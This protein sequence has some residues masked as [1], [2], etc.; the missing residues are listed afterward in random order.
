M[1]YFR[2]L[3]TFQIDFQFCHWGSP[4]LDL[5]HLLYTSLNDELHTQEQIETFVQVFYYELK[6]MLI[7]L[8][9]DLKNFPTLHQFQLQFFGKLF[10]GE[11][12]SKI[13]AA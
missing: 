4:A 9:Y 11:N 3:V 12:Q 1:K 10:Y 5:I 8:D 13:I 7:K 2:Q 6:E